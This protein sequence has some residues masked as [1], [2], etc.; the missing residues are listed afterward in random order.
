MAK[1]KKKTKRN[2]RRTIDL[3]FLLIL[4]I[5]CIYAFYKAYTFDMIPKDWV[6][7]AMAPVTIIYLILF[8][9][10]LKKMPTWA[11]VIKRIFIILLAVVLGVGGYF[12]NRV[13]TTTEEIATVNSN[14]K[15]EIYVITKAN[16]NIS[17]IE[18]L[19]G[20]TVGFQEGTDILNATYAQNQIENT[21]SNIDVF[22]AVDY[23]TLYQY[24]TAGQLDAVAISKQ[25]YNM[26]KANEKEFDNEVKTI[27]TY[28]KDPQKVASDIDI[29]KDVF[30]VYISGIDSAGSPDQIARTDVNLIMI[31]NP[32]ANHIDMVSLPRDG[33]IPNVALNSNNDKLTHTAINGI[34]NSI[35]T[36]ENFIGIKI[37][38]YA[39]MSFTS[40]AKIVDAV[41]GIDIDVEI[42]VCAYDE[43]E[44]RT[45]DE[46]ESH[47]GQQVVCVEKGPQHLNGAQ[48]LMYARHRKTEGYDN[49]GRERAQQRVIKGVINKL[50][51]PN[52][53]GYIDT[54][55]K[56]APNFV[57][58]NMPNDQINN[59]I[60]SELKDLKPWTITS[61]ASDT[62]VNDS[63]YVASLDPAL[64]LMDVYL[65]NKDEI[66]GI[67]NAYDGAK[68]AMQLN[69][70]SFD[71]NDLYKNSPALNDDPSFVW[72]TMA[73]YGQ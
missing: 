47:E 45:M 70:F 46:S 30:T 20:K 14:V 4:L 6:F 69:K 73:G 2:F 40:V 19:A 29:T 41:G 50:I 34:D 59:F 42:D 54:L 23:T 9:L 65:F 32:K 36:L 22:T 25:Y 17:S 10:A 51:S 64:G 55:L 49:P 26:T 71:L 44:F 37:D 60:S 7:I 15:T 5:V 63:Q 62:G 61:L 16:S 1:N 56:I 66:Q 11:V 53:L 8:V 52:A 33:F 18:D 57:I 3:V 28:T 21:V 43:S 72:D 13:K 39:R 67:L 24:L 68:K 35:E 31:V 38:F 58:T 48:A 12:V 27:H